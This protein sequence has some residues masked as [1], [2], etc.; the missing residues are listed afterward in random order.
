MTQRNL[1]YMHL[2]EHSS[3]I[4]YEDSSMIFFHD[5]I[6]ISTLL[7]AQS[8]GGGKGGGKGHFLCLVQSTNP[9]KLIRNPR[10]TGSILSATS[11]HSKTHFPQVPPQL[12]GSVAPVSGGLL[13]HD[14]IISL[15]VVSETKHLLNHVYLQRSSFKYSSL[16]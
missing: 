5:S 6:S 2:E 13:A 7:P 12:A 10:D 11:V 14:R 8:N 9:P 16:T 3:E 15:P 1:H 4:I